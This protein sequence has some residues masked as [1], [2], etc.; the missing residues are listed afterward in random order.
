[1]YELSVLKK[2]AQPLL[3]QVR[4]ASVE[5]VEANR[6]LA[7]LQWFDPISPDDLSVIS[8]DSI[9]REFIGGSVLEEFDPWRFEHRLVI[10]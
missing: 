1:V 10:P 7:F 8:G 5:R 2:L 6:L 3:L 4:P 9:L